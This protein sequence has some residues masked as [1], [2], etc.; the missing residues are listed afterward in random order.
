MHYKIIYNEEKLKEFINWLPDLQSNEQYYVQLLARKKYNPETGLKSD[1]S[2][3]KR[4][5]SS[6]ERL[7]HKI[8]QLELPIGRYESGGENISQDNLALYIT[9]NPRDLHKASLLMMR[10][11]SDKLIQN[12]NAINPHALALNIIQTTTSRKIFFDLDIDFKIGNHQ[13]AIN[14]F[15]KDIENCINPDSL[16]F[17]KTNG[18]LHCLIKLGDIKKEYQKNWHQKVSQLTCDEYEVTMNADNVLPVPGAIQGIDFSPYF[19]I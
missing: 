14:Q 1:K 19:L 9:P 13:V 11:I 8:S 18:G 6:K 10:E 16:T 4:F 12:D 5:T 7:F 15:K 2:Q 17:I 3:L